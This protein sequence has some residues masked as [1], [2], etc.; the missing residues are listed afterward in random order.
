RDPRRFHPWDEGTRQGFAVLDDSVDLAE[1]AA[2]RYR[3][4]NEA[5]AWLR[6]KHH[7]H[8]L[9]VPAVLA[10]VRS[11]W[12]ADRG[13]EAGTAQSF[14]GFCADTFCFLKE[15]GRNNT[16]AW[17]EG[18]RDRYRFAVREPL[19]ELCRALAERYVE[20]VLRRTHGWDLE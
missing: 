14:T 11:P 19:V 18:Q 8:P 13:S 6:E 17:M 20:P 10:A 4:F 12:P 3:L 2:T 7:I 9:E 16:R 5:V 1:A 15:L